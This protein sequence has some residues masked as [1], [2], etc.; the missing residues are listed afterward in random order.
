MSESMRLDW[1]YRFTNK[2]DYPDPVEEI[3]ALCTLDANDERTYLL[4]ANRSSPPLRGASCGEV[5]G[6]CTS[7][8][9]RLILHGTAVV[10]GESI[11]DCTPLSV[12]PIYGSLEGRV[13]CPLKDLERLPSGEL[14]DTTLSHAEQEAFLKGQS[15]VKRL[16]PGIRT[17]RKSA[18]SSTPGTSSPEITPTFPSFVFSQQCTAFTVVGLDPTAGTWE[19]KMTQGPK[20]MPSFA[21]RWEAGFRPDDQPLKWHTTNDEF[22]SEVDRCGAILTCIDGPCGTNGPRVRKNCDPWRWDED[23]PRRTRGGELALSRQGINLFWTTQNTVM[24]FAG[25]SRWIARSL[26]LFSECPEQRMIET[27]PHGAFTFLWRLFGGTITPPKK[28]KVAGRNARL[29]LL[30]SFISGLSDEMVPNHDAV[31]A[32]CAALVAGLHQLELTTAFGTPN[33]GGQIWM[34]NGSKLAALLSSPKKI[35]RV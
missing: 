34:P 13:F 24:R 19:S 8:G 32:V 15:F 26:V 27:H 33:D 21:L 23:A 6:L 4:L 10:A 17:A 30:R 11:R 5:I 16:T 22:R 2:A 12:Q 20:K 9:N 14:P 1:L 18:V 3:D 35:A 25:A 31:D 29:S 28:S 7:H